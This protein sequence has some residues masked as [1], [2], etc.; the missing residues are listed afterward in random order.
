MVSQQNLKTRTIAIVVLGNSLMDASGETEAGA[1][2]E[3]PAAQTV[4]AHSL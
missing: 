4:D 3:Q 2:G 1:A